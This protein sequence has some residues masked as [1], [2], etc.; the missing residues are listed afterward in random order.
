M[1]FSS[2]AAHLNVCRRF[3]FVISVQSIG[4]LPRV[5]SQFDEVQQVESD[6]DL[7]PIVLAGVA[8]DDEAAVEDLLAVNLQLRAVH[9][10]AG[11]HFVEEIR[12]DVALRQRLSDSFD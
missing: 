12:R 7:Q 10:E 5:G 9:R 11:E 6:G 3:L 8:V 1:K 4:Q 2:I